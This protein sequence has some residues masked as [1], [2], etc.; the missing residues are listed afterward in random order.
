MNPPRA[1]RS[2]T[3]LR[4]RAA[5]L[6]L[7]APW[8]AG[9][10]AGTG[11]PAEA[12]G[13]PCLRL[14]TREGALVLRLSRAAAPD[15]VAAI[16]RLARGPIW[17]LELVPRPEAARAA[18]Y[19]EGL[20]FDYARPHLELRLPARAPAAAFTVEAELD[21]ARL[22]LDRE[23]VA[24]VGE[25]M[26]LMQF[27]LL[28]A[29]KR[30]NSER[31]ATPVLEEWAR[32]FEVDHDPSFLVGKSRQEI[33][34]AVGFRFRSGLASLPAT[35]GAV[36]LVP[37]SPTRAE[38]SLAILLADHPTR[39]GRWVVVGRVAEGLE[40]ADAISARPLAEPALRDNRPRH[41]VVVEGARLDSTCDSAS[42]GEEP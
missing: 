13:D 25:A 32:R 8:L 17:N 34:E 15:A 33:L 2:R 21:A 6:L 10:S 9:A 36:A 29:L 7:T 27:Q 1:A 20:A 39:T 3:P 14:E 16:E 12:A 4:R 28:P 31:A 41:P 38:L 18:G 35:R 5:A 23:R 30:P 11:R 37:V 24:D 26:D 40:L 19:F 22:G 42:K